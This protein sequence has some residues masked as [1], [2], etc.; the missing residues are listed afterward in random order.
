MATESTL[1]ATMQAV[2]FDAPGDPDVLHVAEVPLPTPVIA[3]SLVRVRAAGVNPIDAK[4]RSG[5]AAA[6]TKQLQYPAIVGGDFSGELVAAPYAAFPLQP[7]DE[8]YGM[9]TVPRWPG[10]Y[11]QYVIA[12]HLT[13]ARKPTNLTHEEAAAVPLAVLTAWGMLVDVARVHTGQRVLIHAGAGGVGHFAVQIARYFGAIVTA[14]GSAR[15]QD[16]LRA[17]GAHRTVDYTAERFE[18]VVDEQDL[19]IDLI[20]NVREDTGTRSL[21]VLRP[22]GLLVNAPTGSWPTMAEEAAAAGIEATTYKLAPATGTLDTITRLFEDG[23]LK[24]HVDKIYDFADAA[25]AH[26]QI[27]SGSTRGKLV[28]RVP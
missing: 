20:G 10:S 18:D 6:T 24:V 11:A 15:N 19:V 16:F 4:T 5:Y 13:I 9:V 8:V 28:I 7:G 3:E 27:E 22:G 1:P 17:L 21:Q 25:E 23:S 12:P 14:T 26:R 2:V